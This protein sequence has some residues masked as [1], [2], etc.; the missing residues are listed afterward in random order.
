MSPPGS[1]ALLDRDG[2][3]TVTYRKKATTSTPPAE[4][5][6]AKRLNIADS[7]ASVL[8][9]SYHCLSSKYLNGVRRCFSI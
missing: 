3:E 2:Y 9:A 7:P 5:P 6:V 4:I 8:A 1:A